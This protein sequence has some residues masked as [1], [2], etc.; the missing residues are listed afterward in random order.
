MLF[1]TAIVELVD[2]GRYLIRGGRQ[3]AS[4]HVGA[5]LPAADALYFDVNSVKPQMHFERQVA[6]VPAGPT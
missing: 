1:L 2:G 4:R 6:L 5:A 3:S